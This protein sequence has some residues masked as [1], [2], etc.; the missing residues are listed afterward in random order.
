VHEWSQLGNHVLDLV[1]S[2]AFAFASWLWLRYIGRFDALA[3]E[4]K[5]TR[6]AEIKKHADEIGSLRTAH[7]RL[8]NRV[9]RC[10]WELKVV[11][12]TDE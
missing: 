8:S 6:D 12:P 5:A 1:A 2:G 9:R 3:K 10:E 11:P 7:G 4:A